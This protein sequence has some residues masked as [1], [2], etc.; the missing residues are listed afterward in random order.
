MP[1]VKTA[2]IVSRP[3]YDNQNEDALYYYVVDGDWTR[4]EGCCAH[5]RGEDPRE[6]ELEA[7]LWDEGG[8]GCERLQEEVTIL[9]FADAIRN[10]ALVVH[11]VENYC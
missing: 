1:D 10:G 7:L 5:G 4:F 2:V 3:G 11:I 8:E 6:A 9:Q